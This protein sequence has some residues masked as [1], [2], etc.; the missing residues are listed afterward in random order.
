VERVGVRVLLGNLPPV[1]AIGLAR[2]LTEDGADVIG[3]ERHPSALVT[4]ADRLRPD[5]V[6]LDVGA[7]GAQELAV[8]VQRVSPGTKVVLCGSGEDAID[9]LDPGAA[10]GPRRV[11]IDAAEGLRLELAATEEAPRPTG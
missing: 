10:D 4:A 9:V 11:E 6:V 8:H 3:D 1:M 5:V 2:I 7:D